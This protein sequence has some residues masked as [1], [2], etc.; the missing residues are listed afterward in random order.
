MVTIVVDR[1]HFLTALKPK[2]GSIMRVPS[3]VDLRLASHAPTDDQV[4]ALAKALVMEHETTLAE[5]Y[6]D[7][8]VQAWGE[9]NELERRIYRRLARVAIAKVGEMR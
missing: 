4:E 7:W 3:D 1:H 9:L 2:P 8:P 5:A 6:P